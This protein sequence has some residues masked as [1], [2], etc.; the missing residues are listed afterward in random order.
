MILLMVAGGPVMLAGLLAMSMIGL[1]EFYRALRQG[2]HKPFAVVGMAAAALYY[3][4]VFFLEKQV[5][6]GN[7]FLYFV[8][9]LLVLLMVLCVTG[10][11]ERSVEDAALTLLGVIYVAVFFSLLYR[12][13]RQQDGQF[14]V[15]YVFLASWGCDTC[16]YLAGRAFGRRK[17]VPELSPHK[18]VAGAVG[19]VAGGILLSLV[20][21]L[22]IRSHVGMEP[23][24]LFIMAALCGLV[25]AVLSQF[26]DLFAS[27]V[28]RKTGIKD[29][30]QLIPGHGG[31]LDRFDSTLMVTPLI[32]L[33]IDLFIRTAG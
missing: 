2:A 22:F 23:V 15:W 19:G 26:G 5:F 12:I 27:A 30:G 3:V 7:L 8:I 31:I 14:F 1:Y 28:K 33:L 21:T 9:G 17:L 25:G 10:Y 11:P 24:R 29:Y 20:Y 16:A 32:M 13:R 6:E 18:T 4:G